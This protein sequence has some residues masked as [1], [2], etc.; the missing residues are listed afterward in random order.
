M[1]AS[2]VGKPYNKLSSKNWPRI[3]IR[4]PGRNYFTVNVV[5]KQN[6][7]QRFLKALSNNLDNVDKF[8]IILP[9]H[10]IKFTLSSYSYLL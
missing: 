10:L 7:A 8:F 3:I 2:F 9:N 1:I 6:Y 4:P 5:I